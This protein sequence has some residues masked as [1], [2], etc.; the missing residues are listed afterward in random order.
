MFNV[1]FWF[2]YFCYRWPFVGE[3]FEENSSVQ[4]AVQWNWN[5]T[6]STDKNAC[7]KENKT[8]YGTDSA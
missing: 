1:N 6:A 8:F 4:C 5:G 2:N 7:T 3:N